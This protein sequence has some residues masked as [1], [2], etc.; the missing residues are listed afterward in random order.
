LL[1][2]ESNLESL[3]SRIID[4]ATSLM[5][6]DMASIQL[7]D[8]ER[9]QLR[10]LAWKGF[11]LQSAIFW[12]LAYLDSASTCG[13]ALSAGCRVVVPDIEACNF[14]AGTA[15]LDEYRRSN[16]RAVQSTPLLSR[17][18]Q[19]LGMISTHWREPYQP[20]G[21][22]LLRLDVLARQSA[23]LIERCTTEIALRES[24]EQLLGLASIVE[25]SDDS[26]ITKDL[27]GI[28]R[29]WNKS[30]ERLFGYTADE[31]IGKP[32]TIVI[33]AERR[34]EEPAILA[35]IRR[36]ERIDH[37]E[38]V[39]QRKDGGLLDISLTVSP[40]KNA[41]GK[42]VGASRRCECRADTW[43]GVKSLAGLIRP[44]PGHDAA[45]AD[46]CHFCYECE[47]C[48]TV[49][50]PKAGDC[51]VFCSYGSVSCPPIQLQREGAYVA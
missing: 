10:L 30:A 22:A 37:Y 14:M 17:S 20:T 19:L 7:L 32:V 8:P 21:R 15:D 2:K 26:I 35:R 41:Q 51:C 11:H 34:D 48:D 33:P 3:Y 47:G 28:I 13:L 12:E 40:I 9:N 36:G 23:D 43:D 24:N 44:V 50:R 1:I 4:A 49:V 39:R 25:S 16:I 27:D 18:G 29:T 38:T 42:I 46:A 6:S 31:A 45:P 5:S